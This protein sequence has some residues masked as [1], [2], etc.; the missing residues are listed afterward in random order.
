MDEYPPDHKFG[1]RVP[2]GGSDCQK[3]R[4]RE[5][6]MCRN[7]Y[8]NKAVGNKIPAPVDEYCCDVFEPLSGGKGKLYSRG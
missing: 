8:F 1:M 5:G 7:P 2:K 6:Q 3:C 4:F